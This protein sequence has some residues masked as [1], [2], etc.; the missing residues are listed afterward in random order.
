ME[1]TNI[2]VTPVSRK[3]KPNYDIEHQYFS[4]GI[5]SPM[6]NDSKHQKTS[7]GDLLGF[8]HVKDDRV[9]VF[10]VE[11][12]QSQ[13]PT[14]W[15]TTQPS[16][17]VLV[18]SRRLRIMSWE[19]LKVKT[20]WKSGRILM[21]ST[22]LYFREASQAIPRRRRLTESQKKRVAA[23]QDFQCAN[24]HPIQ[25]LEGYSCPLRFREWRFDESGYEVDHIK[26]LG[27]G[28]SDDTSNC[29]ALCLCCHRVKTARFKSSKGKVES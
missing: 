27:G 3:S 2:L 5:R 4:S 12:I 24:K 21:G 8:V 25:G 14:D 9:E 17:R 18:L 26:E 1:V 16:N 28:G 13:R 22:N 15:D 6:W 20:M 7:V 29:Q 19:E 10:R 23:R 11:S